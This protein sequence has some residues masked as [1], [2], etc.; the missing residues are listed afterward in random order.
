[1]LGTHGYGQGALCSHG[2]GAILEAVIILGPYC[3]DVQDIFTAGAIASDAFA[4]GVVQS[5]SFIGG[6]EIAQGRCE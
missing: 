5:D 6:V 2:Y 1:M 3:V 4:A